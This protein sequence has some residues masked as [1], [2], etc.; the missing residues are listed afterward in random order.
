[1]ALISSGRLVRV[2]GTGALGRGAHV[3]RWNG[4]DQRGDLV[5]AGTYFYRLD[6]SRGAGS[7]GRIVWIR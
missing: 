7:V 3:F 4:L 6:S 1:M 5:P 2:L